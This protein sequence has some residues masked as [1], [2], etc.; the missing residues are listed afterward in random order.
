M[1]ANTTAGHS[2]PELSSPPTPFHTHQDEVGPAPGHFNPVLATRAADAPETR[3]AKRQELPIAIARD[4]G[5]MHYGQGPD[6]RKEGKKKQGAGV[7]PAEGEA[8]HP[9]S[10]RMEVCSDEEL[11][12]GLRVNN[13]LLS[14]RQTASVTLAA[15]ALQCLV[16]CLAC[17]GGCGSIAWTLTGEAWTRSALRLSEGALSGWEGAGGGGLG[18][19]AISASKA[20]S[21][22]QWA[23]G[24]MHG[25]IQVSA[26]VPACPRLSVCV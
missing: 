25:P 1:Q 6:E 4:G 11:D 10:V 13:N 5:C 9:S 16:P 2:T 23:S 7:S 26:S 22:V 12:K 18:R 3:L 19:R 24:M 15:H 8:V 14:E 17:L 20:R 21:S